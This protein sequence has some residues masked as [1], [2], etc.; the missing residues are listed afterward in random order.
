MTTEEVNSIIFPNVDPKF[1]MIGLQTGKFESVEHLQSLSGTNSRGKSLEEMAKLASGEAEVQGKWIVRENPMAEN[2]Q[3][4]LISSGN[5]KK[6]LR[7]NMAEMSH[8][9]QSEASTQGTNSVKKSPAKAPERPPEAVQEKIPSSS[10]GFSEMSLEEVSTIDSQSFELVDL[11]EVKRA[12]GSF[13]NVNGS[14]TTLSRVVGASRLFWR[15]F[16]GLF[17]FLLSLVVALILTVCFKWILEGSSEM[18]E[19]LIPT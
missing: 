6:G 9:A 15:G 4:S 7:K 8:V 14:K 17:L 12:K 3:S 1:L 11:E 13:V 18:R 16:E 2:P 19:Y 10:G 5:E